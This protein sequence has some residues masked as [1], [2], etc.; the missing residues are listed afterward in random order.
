[1]SAPLLLGIMQGRLV[2]PETDF[3]QTFPRARW[4]EEF[5]RAE[6][7]GLCAI[8]WIYD[9]Y[10]ED[11]NPLASDEGVAEM[12]ALARRYGVSVRSLCADW[13]MEHPLVTAD[14]DGRAAWVERLHWLVARASLAGMGRIVLPFVDAAA[15]R[16]ERDELAVVD[17]L[18]TVLPAA[19][20]ARE[21]LHLETALGPE[22]FAALLARL[23]HPLVRA[24]YDTGNSAALGY[25]PREEFAAYGDRVG[26]VHVKD[27]R[28]GGGTVPL[29]TGD[30]DLVAV[31]ECLREVG[32]RGDVV[33]Q[34]ARGAPEGEVA[35]AAHNRTT[36]ERLWREVP[37]WS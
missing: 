21:E 13:L 30:A 23:P 12:A 29:G 27:R 3:V 35:W 31:G 16:D 10:G 25:A 15:I 37:A 36:V 7:A 8:E 28:R 24:N 2:P 33:L 19:E 32:Y 6:A 17:A 5:P 26:S 20:A 14:A 34:V 11:A 4:R 9:S 22:A 1:M 18:L